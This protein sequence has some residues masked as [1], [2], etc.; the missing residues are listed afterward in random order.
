MEVEDDYCQRA[1]DDRSVGKIIMSL[2]WRGVAATTIIIIIIII[3][4]V[5]K[6]PLSM[7]PLTMTEAVAIN[8][9]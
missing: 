1:E 2:G 8:N 3:K 6:Q 4:S 7:M 9:S 5:Q